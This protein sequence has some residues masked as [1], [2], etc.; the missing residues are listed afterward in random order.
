[1]TDIAK[2]NAMVESAKRISIPILGFVLLLL[3]MR[4]LTSGRN[5][6][7]DIDTGRERQ[8]AYAKT[9]SADDNKVKLPAYDL[10]SLLA[11]D[12]FQ[13]IVVDLPNSVAGNSSTD[14][15]DSSTDP[16]LAHQAELQQPLPISAIIQDA[17]GTAALLGATIVREGDP[18]QQGYRVQRITPNGIFLIKT[19]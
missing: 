5:S 16:G 17:N 12:P 15:H 7:D 3:V 19:E 18:W 13:P 8:R 1:M 2:R 14:V 9:K 4:P 6:E 11:Y 10:D